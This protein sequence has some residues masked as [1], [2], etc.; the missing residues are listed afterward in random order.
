MYQMPRKA[1]QLGELLMPF[2]C[3]TPLLGIKNT[4][5]FC[6]N[7]YNT[8]PILIEINMHC[9]GQISH[10]VWWNFPTYMNNVAILPCKNLKAELSSSRASSTRPVLQMLLKTGRTGLKILDGLV[11]FLKTETEPNFCFSLTLSF[12]TVCSWLQLARY[13]LQHVTMFVNVLCMCTRC[14]SAV[15]SLPISSSRLT[16]TWLSTS[17]KA[18]CAARHC[19]RMAKNHPWVSLIF[20]PHVCRSIDP[21]RFLAGWRKRRPGF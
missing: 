15:K 7:F 19:W 14:V 21:L 11:R 12:V 3:I 10:R 16:C 9:L 1:C 2:I 6:H 5:I 20:C 8:W 17:V 18:A 4:N 13:L